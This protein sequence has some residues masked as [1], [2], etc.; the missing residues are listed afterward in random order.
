MKKKESDFENWFENVNVKI[1]LNL[2][3]KDFSKRLTLIANHIAALKYI[4]LQKFFLHF[5][6]RYFST[7][8]RPSILNDLMDK[9][10][11]DL[12]PQ[13]RKPITTAN[14]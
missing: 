7:L 8:N 5:L 13:N 6:H 11:P 3:I 1:K 12:P 14:V 4:Y 10:Y 2:E 9:K